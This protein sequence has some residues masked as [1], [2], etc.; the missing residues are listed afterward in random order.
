MLG[1]T[2][3][4]ELQGQKTRTADNCA[5]A[6]IAAFHQRISKQ[7]EAMETWFTGTEIRKTPRWLSF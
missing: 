7:Q 5:D 4:N 3:L 1:G 2:F 6:D